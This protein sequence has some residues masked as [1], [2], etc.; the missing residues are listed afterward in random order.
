VTGCPGE[1]VVGDAVSARVVAGFETNWL[2]V[3]EVLPAFFES[4]P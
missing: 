1:A 3:F 2:T 4:P